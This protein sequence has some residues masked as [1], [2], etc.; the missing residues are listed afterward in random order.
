MGYELYLRGAGDRPVDEAA[1]EQRLKDVGA[2]SDGT[3][4]RA[5]EKGTWTL[6]PQRDE[7]GLLGY[8]LDVPFGGA[9][10]DF[11]AAVGVALSLADAGPL[12]VFDPQLGKIVSK[13]SEDDIV[14]AWRRVASW[15]VDVAGAWEDPRAIAPYEPPRP[16]VEPRTKLLLLVIGAGLFAIWLVGRVLSVAFTQP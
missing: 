14:G 6:R 8:D 13:A 11:L 3:R 1:V 7:R 9:E 4:F 10:P 5:G 15:Q 16:L 12:T 2:R